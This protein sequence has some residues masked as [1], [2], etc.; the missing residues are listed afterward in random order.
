VLSGINFGSAT[1]I[2]AANNVTV[3][4]C[5]FSD[6]TSFWTISQN[7]GVS[8]A[9]VENCT[10]TGSKSPTEKNVWIT[11]QL[12]I[13]IE[14]NT[15]LNSPADAIA[16]QQGVVTGNYFSG[17]GYATAAHGDS[18]YVPDTTGPITITDNFI[19]DTPNA[20]ATGF[21]NTAMRITDEFGNTNDV[22]ATGNYLIGAGFNFEVGAPNTSYTVSNVS[23][24]NNYQGF[25]AFGQYFPTTPQYATV[26]G[27]TTI[28]FS[29]PAAST[30]ALAAYIAAEAFQQR[31]SSP[32][33]PRLRRPP[34]GR[35]PRRS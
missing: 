23:I 30:Q 18:I 14:N 2:I 16:L 24:T 13:T 10:F 12:G 8:G 22:T 25:A 33:P 28:D 21:S 19:H 17:E 32:R 35:R 1:V 29:N 3:K 26:G 4:D 15:F 9:T 11:S 20:G 31:R 5:T 34:P 7:N 6:T 27:I